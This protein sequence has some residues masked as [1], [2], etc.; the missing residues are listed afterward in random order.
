[1]QLSFWI[2]SNRV[3]PMLTPIQEQSGRVRR[4]SSFLLLWE[5]HAH[6]NYGVEN[7]CVYVRMT[8]AHRSLLSSVQVWLPCSTLLGYTV[9]VAS[10]GDAR[11]NPRGDGTRLPGSPSAGSWPP[12]GPSLTSRH[13]ISPPAS[14]SLR[15]ESS[16][17]FRFLGGSRLS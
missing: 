4:D 8:S 17:I 16:R 10:Q 3:P 2:S 15:A 5:R 7:V 12:P 9:L 13:P 11:V 6:R 14:S 1:M